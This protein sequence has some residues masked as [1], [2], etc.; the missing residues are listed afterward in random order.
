MRETMQPVGVVEWD[1]KLYV[2]NDFDAL[3]DLYAED[4]E[5]VLA[6]GSVLRSREEVM[7]YLKREEGA[8][9][10]ASFDWEIVAVD[11][12]TVVQAWTWSAKHTGD[13]TLPSGQALPAS[14]RE[15]TIEAVNVVRIEDGRVKYTR[16]YYDRLGVL[17]Q[18]GL[19]PG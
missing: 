5:M 19:V 13:L 4:M 3:A 2:E 11:G 9:S 16:R 17:A 12:P 10:D 8:F 15:V 18:L 6:D 14:D 1:G 7:D